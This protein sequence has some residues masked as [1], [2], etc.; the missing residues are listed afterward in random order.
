MEGVSREESGP[1][2]WRPGVL[3]LLRAA[4]LGQRRALGGDRPDT[5]A[6]GEH[7]RRVVAQAQLHSS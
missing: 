1:N 3:R 5:V 7:L 4:L 2:P 6:S